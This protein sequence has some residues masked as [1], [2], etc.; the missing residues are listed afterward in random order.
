MTRFSFFKIFTVYGSYYAVV[1]VWIQHSTVEPDF[2]SHSSQLLLLPLCFVKFSVRN[3]VSSLVVQTSWS[4][5][6]LYC[7]VFHIAAAA[8]GLE[9]AAGNSCHGRFWLHPLKAIGKR[10][11]CQ[12]HFLF[13]IG[14]G[15]SCLCKWRYR[16][17]KELILRWCFVEASPQ[18]E[19]CFAALW[20]GGQRGTWWGRFFCKN[21]STLNLL[22]PPST[23][24]PAVLSSRY[25]CKK[26]T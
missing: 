4:F 12:Y 18:R 19:A 20:L 3:S 16:E 9:K 24:V 5:S 21:A 14:L 2:L 15:Y 22:C 8:K 13:S 10:R 26:R 11:A 17:A 7:G 1:F 25:Y 6:D 23:A